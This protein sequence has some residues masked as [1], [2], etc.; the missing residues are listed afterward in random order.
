VAIVTRGRAIPGRLPVI[1]VLAGL[2]VAGVLV[3]RATPSTQ[4]AAGPAILPMPAAAPA[5][6]LSSSWFCAGPAN[7]PAGVAAGALVLVNATGQDHQASIVLTGGHGPVSSVTVDVGPYRRVSVPEQGAEARLPYTGAIVD[8]DGGGVAV[9]QTI[10]GTLGP[11]AAACA[12]AGSDQWFFAD[13]TTQEHAS[14]LLSLLNPYPQDAIVDLS[15]LTESGNEAPDAFQGIVVPARSLVGVDVGSH[16][17]LRARVATTVSARAGRVV[18]WK[19][20]VLSSPP[21]SP[22][23]AFPIP[24]AP[25]T[26]TTA[27]AP[28]PSGSAGGAGGATPAASG[29][30]G[31]SVVLGSPSPG[32]T[33]WWPDGVAANGVAERFVIY[34]PGPAEAYV[35]LAVILDAG[36]AEPFALK[37]EAHDTLTVDAG[38]EARIPRGVAHAAVLQSTN[39]IGVVAERTVDAGAPSPR[40]G[41]LELLGARVAARRWV[42]A[43]GR[44]GPGSDEWVEIFNPGRTATTVSVAFL[45]G[46]GAADLAGLGAL[47]VPAGRRLAVRINQHA[48]ALDQPLLVEAGGNV[49]VER[50]LYPTKGRGLD[51]A[52][53]VPLEA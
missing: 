18:A 45:T 41:R 31:V 14:L 7:Q 15:F 22:P 47:P 50:D 20:Q 38:A 13:G 46:A 32:T 29:V 5:A 43:S 52:M 16:L 33:W 25:S 27:L 26:T 10:A 3:D 6:A 48:A 30:P 2:L 51:A 4:V 1:V 28:R 39:G 12:T 21:A 8:V 17:R 36:S 49:V 53:G 40:S 34:N 19:T 23:A 35:S 11:S 9:E 37:V 42:L 44:A 24:A